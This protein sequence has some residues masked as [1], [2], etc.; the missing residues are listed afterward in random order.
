[1]LKRE[2]AGYIETFRKGLIRSV[3]MVFQD[4]LFAGDLRNLLHAG[5]SRNYVMTSIIPLTIANIP[6]RVL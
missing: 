6:D 1:M 5:A 2:C 3:E 4:A